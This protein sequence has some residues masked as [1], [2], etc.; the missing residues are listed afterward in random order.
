MTTQEYTPYGDTRPTAETIALR[1]RAE[2]LARD[3]QDAELLALVPALRA[4]VQMWPHLWGPVAAIAARRTG[5]ADAVDLL[6]D[7]VANGFS[8]PELFGDALERQFGSGPE[9]V[10]L[11]AAMA[12]NVPLPTVEL[13]EW[14]D[15]EPSLPLTLYAIDTDRVSALRAR[16]PAPAGAAWDTAQMLLAWVRRCWEHANDHVDDPDALDV[17]H[18][19]DAGERFACVEYS[20]VLSQALNAVGIPSRR[21]DLRQRNHHVGV[22]RGHVV[23]E[24]WID[25]LDAWVVL[26]GQNG[27]YWT[28]ADDT[29]PLGLLELQ[30]LAAAGDE[31]PTM[32][33]LVSEMT[34]DEAR[35][36]FTYFASASTTGCAW[37]GAGYSPI[38]Q[39]MGV[40]KAEL[41]VHDGRAAYPTLSATSIGL[42]GTVAQPMVRL[43]T[44][45]PYARGFSVRQDG[46]V[47]DVDLDDPRWALSTSPGLHDADIAVRTPYGTCVPSTLRY[48]IRAEAEH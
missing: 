29:P 39:G 22:G 33:G 43:A 3:E 9:W 7:A 30:R 15:P 38:F 17:L 18:R 2:R 37:A 47:D 10:E 36:W 45:H 16:L 6:R 25:D 26:D 27:S 1:L 42:S 31:V 48:V 19:V 4:D 46:I 40:T 14:P 20:I 24:A 32:V 5:R 35:S 41:L 12:D 13:L 8:Q 21:V 44:P 11:L 23:A 28:S 34:A